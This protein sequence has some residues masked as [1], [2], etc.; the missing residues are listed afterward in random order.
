MSYFVLDTRTNQLVGTA[1]S[2]EQA[3]TSASRNPHFSALYMGK[4]CLRTIAKLA[5][6]LVQEV[7]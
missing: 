5:R 6:V 7:V 3:N 1:F 4:T 2:L